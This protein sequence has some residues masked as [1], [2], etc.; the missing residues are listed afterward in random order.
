MRLCHLVNLSVHPARL[1][2]ARAG[3]CDEPEYNMVYW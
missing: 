2:E 3:E 1:L